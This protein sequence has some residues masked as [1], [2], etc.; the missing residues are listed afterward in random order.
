MMSFDTHAAVKALTTAGASE[1]IAAAVVDVA[2]EAAAEHQ[3]ELAT[4]AD[5]A[6]LRATV[7]AQREATRADIETLR[8]A[9]RADIETLRETT[10]AD[11]ETLR[12][13]FDA[14]REA[15]RADFAELRATLDTQREAIRA[16]FETLRAGVETFREATRADIAELRAEQA[17]RETRLIKW[18]VGTALVVGTLI[19]GALRL[20]SLMFAE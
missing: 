19:V 7:D 11:I 15:T 18:V 9:T 4:R 12:A 1:E 2:R 8:E 13:A 16:D 10:R 5:V 17:G 14:Q 3:R 6:E 20:L